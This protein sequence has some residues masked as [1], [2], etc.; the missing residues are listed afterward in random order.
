MRFRRNGNE[1]AA[2]SAL[3]SMD[4]GDERLNSVPPVE[5]KTQ[6][7][8]NGTSKSS[9]PKEDHRKS[10]RDRRKPEEDPAQPAGDLEQSEEDHFESAQDSQEVAGDQLLQHAPWQSARAFKYSSSIS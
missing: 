7:D 2:R 3:R 9:E 10:E 6:G 1:L 5:T 8:S 4:A